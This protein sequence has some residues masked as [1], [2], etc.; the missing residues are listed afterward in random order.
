MGQSVD[1]QKYKGANDMDAEYYR[2]YRHGKPQGCF[3]EQ[4]IAPKVPKTVGSVLRGL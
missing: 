3:G 4:V 1:D 2:K